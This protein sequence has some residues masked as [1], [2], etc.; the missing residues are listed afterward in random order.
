MSL[1]ALGK[2]FIGV[3]LTMLIYGVFMDTS[4][5]SGYGRVINIGL[6]NDRLMYIMIGGFIFLGGVILFG[7]YKVKQTKEE[8]MIE[9][10]ESESRRAEIKAQTIKK[11]KSM[12]SNVAKDFVIQRLSHA[13][14]IAFLVTYISHPVV[15]APTG[16]VVFF[17][18]LVVA[19][20]LRPINH[21][22]A[23]SHGWLLAALSMIVVIAKMLIQ[24][25]FLRDHDFVSPMSFQEAILTGIFLIPAAIFYFVSRRFAVK[26][27]AK[28]DM[29]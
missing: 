25:I 15:L 12:S 21:R 17:Y 22:K 8:E 28:D 16:L 20:M 9:K 26:S 29:V 19:L 14:V 18:I 27:H 13:L 5:S 10:D 3:G 4:V 11:T 6:A 7:I 23:I 24:G 1:K 2:L